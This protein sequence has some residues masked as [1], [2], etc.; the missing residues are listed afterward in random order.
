MTGW[1]HSETPSRDVTP[2]P[3]PACSLFCSHVSYSELPTTVGM[4]LHNSSNQGYYYVH[5]A[6]CAPNLLHPQVVS[7]NSYAFGLSQ[8]LAST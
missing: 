8:G 4:Y 3:Q 7:L 2:V 6:F 1:S 5:R